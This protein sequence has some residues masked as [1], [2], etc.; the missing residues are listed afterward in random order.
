MELIR[1]RWHKLLLEDLVLR[2]EWMSLKMETEMRCQN[3]RMSSPLPDPPV[4]RSMYAHA[5]WF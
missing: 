5:G 4:R 1:Q 2:C 3:R